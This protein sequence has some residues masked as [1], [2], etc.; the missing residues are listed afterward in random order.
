MDSPVLTDLA[1]RS[2]CW[3]PRRLGRRLGWLLLALFGGA[4]G[5]ASWETVCAVCGSNFHVVK[6]GQAYRSGQL[7]PEQFQKVIADYGIRTVVN[8]RGD[9]GEAEWYRRERLAVA[10][11]GGR[12]EN[13]MLA[14]MPAPTVRD[15][16]RLVRLLDA[17]PRPVLLHCCSGM[18]RSS[19]AA[20][21]FLLL[22]S[23]ATLAEA[24]AQMSWRYGHLA[25][26]RSS[27]LDR[28]LDQYAAWLTSQ[29]LDHGPEHFRHWA[30]HVYREEYAAR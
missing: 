11:A 28:V 8:L 12:L 19:F 29:G 2:G 17:A 18:D 24:R 14:A 10:E 23:D 16:S 7:A 15:L 27:C 13:S 9:G 22:A 26:G 3:K 20:A 1:D 21:V 5:A 25:S 30:T 6:P 4:A